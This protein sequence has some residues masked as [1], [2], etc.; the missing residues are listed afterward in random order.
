MFDS[1]FMCSYCSPSVFVHVFSHSVELVTASL[2]GSELTVGHILWPMT[3]VTHQSIDSCD[4]WPMTYDY[5]PQQSLSQCDVCVNRHSSHRPTAQLPEFIRNDQMPPVAPEPWTT[6]FVAR[7][8]RPVTTSSTQNPNQSPNLRKRCRWSGTACHRNRSTRLIKASHYDWRHAQK[9]TMNN[10][11]TQSD[12]QTSDKM[13]TA[14]FQLRCIS[15]FRRKRFTARENR[16]V[17]A[18]KYQ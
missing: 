8:W 15:V 10:L 14:L 16:K 17:V 13:F 5:S 7:C 2:I 12:C 6:M 3:H 9:L 4:P 18:L 11:G 1:H